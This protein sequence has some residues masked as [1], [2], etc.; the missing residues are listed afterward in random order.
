M[1][2]RDRFRHDLY[3]R[4][5][6]LTVRLPPLAERKAD[7]G[8]LVAALLPRITSAPITISPRAARA[9]HRHDWPLNV[10][11]LERCLRAAALLAEDGRIDLPHL[12]AALRAGAPAARAEDD[13]ARRRRTLETL[14]REHDGNISAVARA[15]GTSRVQVHRWLKRYGLEKGG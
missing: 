7:L 15:L 3:A 13:D 5:T 1:V 2:G 8:L 14:L 4:L 10:R 9:L 6:G 11:E 12:P